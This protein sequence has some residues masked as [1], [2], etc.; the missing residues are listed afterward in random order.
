MDVI[1]FKF[2][3][4]GAGIVAAAYFL[5]HGLLQLQQLLMPLMHALGCKVC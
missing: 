5:G 2:G 3:L 1:L 4:L